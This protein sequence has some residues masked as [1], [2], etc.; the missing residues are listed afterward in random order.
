MQSSVNN[1]S[2]I[3][4]D[5]EDEN[6][7]SERLEGRGSDS[8][9]KFENIGIKIN[10]LREKG[11]RKKDTIKSKVADNISNRMKQHTEKEKD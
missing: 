9:L 7:V 1:D 8:T 10:E 4:E 6:D 3:L 2:A 11:E 5:S